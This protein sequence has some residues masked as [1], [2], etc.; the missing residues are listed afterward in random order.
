MQPVI[1]TTKHR[2]IFCGQLEKRDGDTVTIKRCR[3]AISFKGTGAV[4]LSN[5]PTGRVSGMSESAVINDVTAVFDCS[6]EGWQAWEAVDEK[7][8]QG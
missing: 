6:D 7:K 3:M 1:V 4:G 5:G 8:G 2:G